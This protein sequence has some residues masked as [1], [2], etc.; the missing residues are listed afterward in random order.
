MA[1]NMPVGPNP[2][3]G[4]HYEYVGSGG[5]VLGGA[6]VTSFERVVQAPD[7][8]TILTQ[9]LFISGGKTDEGQIIRAVSVPWFEIVRLIQ[10]GPSIVHQIDHRKWE[11]IIAT[12]YKQAGFDEVT[13]TPQRGDRGRDVIAVK[14][15]LGTI[16]VIDQVKA[17]KPPHLVEYDDVRALIGVLHGDKAS[18]GFLTTTSDF[19]PKLRSDPL[20]AEFMP[21]R[22]ELVNGAALVQRLDE[23]A[24]Q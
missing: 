7:L 22:L 19:A 4:K 6:A 24:T 11:E 23:L 12:A 3:D 16:R 10:Q 21:A 20:I 1:N 2:A 5:I 8:P 18:K 13:L 9:A 14:K 17:Y 15:G